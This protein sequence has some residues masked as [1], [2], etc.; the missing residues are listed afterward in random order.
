M[1]YILTIPQEWLCHT[2]NSVGLYNNG[3]TLLESS[4]LGAWLKQRDLSIDIEDHILVRYRTDSTYKV[5]IEMDIE[6]G[7]EF[8]MAWAEIICH[9]N[10]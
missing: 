10:S 4:P 5:H 9:N 1:T 6:H 7:V 3:N 8:H 2:F